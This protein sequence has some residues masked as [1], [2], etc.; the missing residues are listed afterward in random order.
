MHAL[1]HYLLG[2]PIQIIHAIALLSYRLKFAITTKA[3]SWLS[4]N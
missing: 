3:M 4:A 1:L 2:I